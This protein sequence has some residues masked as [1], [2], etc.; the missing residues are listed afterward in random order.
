MRA[1]R[2]ASTGAL[3]NGVAAGRRLV[4][5]ADRG[6]RRRRQP[7][8][9]RSPRPTVQPR[10]ARAVT[11]DQRTVVSLGNRRT[12]SRAGP[13]ITINAAHGSPLFPPGYAVAVRD[14][15]NMK[16]NANVSRPP[17]LERDDHDQEQ[18]STSAGTSPRARA[19]RQRSAH[20]FTQCPGYN[21]TAGGRAVR[22]PA[23][24]HLARPRR[25]TTTCGITNMK[26]GSGTPQDTCSSC[27]KIAWSSSTKVLDDRARRH[28]GTLSGNVYLFCRLDFKNGD[29]QDPQPLDAAVHLHRHAGELRRHQRHGLGGHGRDVHEPVL[30]AHWRSRYWLPA[31]PRRPPA[32][33]CR[34]TTRTARSASTRRTRP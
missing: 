7:T 4:R 14:S 5:A 26:A 24:R 23:G 6:P 25:R 33:T 18:R 21:T 9:S 17:R 22:P 8:A 16:N 30:A 13:S 31:A 27:N 29:D 34:T 15:I 10:P 11:V 12:A 3:T 19:R 1:R 2:T 32:S 20:N 28:A